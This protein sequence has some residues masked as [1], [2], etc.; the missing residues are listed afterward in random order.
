MM[1]YWKVLNVVVILGLIFGG[2]S[3]TAQASVPAGE[4]DIAPA[5]TPVP[6]NPYFSSRRITTDQGQEL[7]EYNIHGPAHPPAGYELERQ[8]VNLSAPYQSASSVMLDVPAYD[9]VYGCS[10]VSGAMIAAYY[11][12]NGLADMYTGPT[13]GGVMPVNS[14]VWPTWTDGAGDTYPNNP[15]VASHAGL[16]GRGAKGSID[17][18][19]VAVDSY[20]P[21]PY[22]SYSW[23]AHAWGDAIG[24]FMKTGQS[25]VGN[26]DGSTA[27]Y[28]YRYS[29]QPFYCSDM[30][31][32]VDVA[33]RDGTYGR[34]LF[35]ESKGYTVTECY[36]QKTNNYGGGFTFEKFKAEI[37]AGQPVLLN[38]NGHSIVGVGYDAATNR[39]FIHDTWDYNTYAMNWGGSYEGM[40]LLS[41]SVVNISP[42]PAVA[43]FFPPSAPVGDTVL[44]RGTNLSG[45]TQVRF[46]GVSASFTVVSATTIE[47]IVPEGAVSGP[48]SVVTPLGT[49][50]S[51]SNFLIGSRPVYLPAVLQ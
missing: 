16:D 4:P 50:T 41:V 26:K 10:A 33:A 7:D 39:I 28:T 23:S 6:D 12:R 3:L 21:D 20:A 17:D 9:W 14:S 37:D 30:E 42:V 48:V 51:S 8:A 1:P 18:Y 40:E 25:E 13:N 31:E 32:D 38:L 46:N 22:I 45:A 5:Q 29:I 43:R 35:Y 44:I 11:D 36:N 2:A 24:D 27:F 19:W 47:A 34:K 49:A 15:L